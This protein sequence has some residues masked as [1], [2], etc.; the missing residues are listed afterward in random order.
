MILINADGSKALLYNQEAFTYFDVYLLKRPNAEND[1]SE[2]EKENALDLATNFL[3]MKK[4][5]FLKM[6]YWDYREVKSI[7][8]QNKFCRYWIITLILIMIN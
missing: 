5:L 7:L 4:Q 6:Y 8:Q 3:K 2:K 1:Y